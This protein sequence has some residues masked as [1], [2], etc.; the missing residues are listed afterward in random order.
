MCSLCDHLYCLCNFSINLKYSKIKG[1]NEKYYE[2][3]ATFCFIFVFSWYNYFKDHTTSVLKRIL[4]ISCQYQCFSWPVAF[5]LILALTATYL[6][7]KLPDS[8]ILPILGNV[9]LFPL[10]I[11]FSNGFSYL[12]F[13]LNLQHYTHVCAHTH[14]HMHICTSLCV[15]VIERDIFLVC[16]FSMM[17]VNWKH[18]F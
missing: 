10:E 1:C 5:N 18:W 14:P 17:L 15:C 11:K 12:N 4:S 16:R 2:H 6:L 3:T 9:V 13:D 8:Y 7:D